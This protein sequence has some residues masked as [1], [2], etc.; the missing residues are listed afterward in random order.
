VR[1]YAWELHTTMERCSLFLPLQR[2]AGLVVL[3]LWL[4]WVKQ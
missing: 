1:R 4:E 3:M 2:G